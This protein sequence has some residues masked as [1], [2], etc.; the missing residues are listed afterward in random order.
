MISY[1]AFDGIP[2][3]RSIICIAIYLRYENDHGQIFNIKQKESR[4]KE[5][6]LGYAGIDLMGFRTLVIND[7]FYGPNRQ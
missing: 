3:K 2:I 4:A 7:D 1:Q 6:S 5:W